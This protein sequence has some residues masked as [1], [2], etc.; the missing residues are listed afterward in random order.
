[1]SP[2]PTT[3][4]TRPHGD[5]HD[6]RADAVPWERLMQLAQGGDRAAY[7][8]LL[9]SI[10]PYVR[11]IARRHLGAGEDTEDAVQEILMVVHGIRHTY[12]PGRPFKP[13][14]GTIASRR[15]IDLLRKRTHRLRH[16]FDDF[17]ALPEHLLARQDDDA[18]TPLDAASRAESA[19][20]LREAVD[21][22]PERQREAVR[23]LRL[24][25]LSLGEAA[26]HSAQSTGALKVAYHRALKSL[27]RTLGNT[28]EAPDRNHDR[29]QD[30]TPSNAGRRND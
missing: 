27:R 11:A 30:D 13:W 22:L 26:E 24:K 2:E 21:A 14:L 25:E 8:A 9:E 16:E 6:P 4:G 19:R 15:C 28:G 17:D 1:M 20:A 10:V 12:E 29:K 3:T 7:H 23:L 18:A 5:R